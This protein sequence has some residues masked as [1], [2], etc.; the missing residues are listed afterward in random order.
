MHI[1]AQPE[2]MPDNPFGK[3]F[4]SYCKHYKLVNVKTMGDEYEQVMEYSFYLKLKNQEN[5]GEL[6]RELRKVEGVLS[7]NLF[8]DED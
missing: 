7:V 5:G 3:T 4:E 6:I 8:F 2:G 1:T